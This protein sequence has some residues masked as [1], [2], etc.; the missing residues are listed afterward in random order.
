VEYTKFEDRKDRVKIMN[1]SWPP[2]PK[3]GYSRYSQVKDNK[4][5]KEEVEG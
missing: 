5:T 4:Y 2:G 1:N 3:I